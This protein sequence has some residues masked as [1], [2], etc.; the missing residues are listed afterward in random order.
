MTTSHPP[1]RSKMRGSKRRKVRLTQTF[2][3]KSA[4]LALFYRMDIP[5]DA[6]HWRKLSAGRIRS[7]FR[8]PPNSRNLSHLP[9]QTRVVAKPRITVE[10]PFGEVVKKTGLASGLP[11]G[12][13]TQYFDHET[14]LV[15]AKRRYY[16][17]STGRWLSRDKKGEKGGLN[18]YSYVINRPLNSTDS[19]GLSVD[20]YT[21]DPNTVPVNPATAT[22]VPDLVG[23]DGY[24]FYPWTRSTGINMFGH[25]VVVGGHLTVTSYYNQDTAPD[26]NAAGS[27]WGGYTVVTHERHHIAIVKAWWNGWK[28]EAD[29]FEGWYCRTTCATLALA[30]VDASFDYY[31]WRDDVDQANFHASLG[32]TLDGSEQSAI[33]NTAIQSAYWAAWAAFSSAGCHY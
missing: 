4:N 7:D 3:D 31:M 26:P 15:Y 12:W 9:R 20:A 29:P 30:V 6:H 11:F 23:H 2:H 25:H 14:G 1:R 13:S 32:L 19:Y 18:Y 8:N 17:P 27:G 33:N 16:Q 24:T 5:V 21:A 10:G 28:A 22:S